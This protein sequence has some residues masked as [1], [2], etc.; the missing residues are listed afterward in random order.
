MTID[1]IVLA[2][3]GSLIL[4]SVLLAV[5]HDQRWLWLTAFVGANM[6]QSAFTGF[7]PLAILLKKLGK[8]PGAA[9]E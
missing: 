1:R 6:L 4:I 5:F 3:A 7:C 2:V 9:F 8:R